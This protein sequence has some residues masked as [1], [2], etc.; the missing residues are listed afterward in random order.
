MLVQQVI[1][2]NSSQENQSLDQCRPQLSM[3]ISNSK[4]KKADL[5]SKAVS[6]VR[7]AIFRLVVFIREDNAKADRA[8]RFLREAKAKALSYHH[9]IY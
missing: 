7:T 4:A 5:L 6:V 2:K 3:V 8:E 1:S 9:R